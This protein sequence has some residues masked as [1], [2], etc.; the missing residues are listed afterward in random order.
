MGVAQIREELHQ[1][2]NNADERILNLMYGMMK[3]DIKKD[4]ALEESIARGLEQSK[5]G[6]VREHA[7]VIAEIRARYKS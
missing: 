5:K 1:F 4:E 7:A 3:A 2:I 6:E